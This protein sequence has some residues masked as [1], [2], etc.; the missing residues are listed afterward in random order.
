MNKAKLV[1]ELAEKMNITQEQS[2]QLS[3]SFRKY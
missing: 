2:R 1:N 3:M